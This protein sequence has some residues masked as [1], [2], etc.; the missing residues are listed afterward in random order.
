MLIIHPLIKVSEKNWKSKITYADASIHI[1]KG[2]FSF[3]ELEIQTSAAASP[4]WLLAIRKL[5]VNIDYPSWFM[6][7]LKID[8][9][10][11]H[12]IIFSRHE[13]KGSDRQVERMFSKGGGKSEKK[14]DSEKNEKPFKKGVLIKHLIIQGKLE[15][16]TVYDSGKSDTVKI[17][18]FNVNKKDVLFDGR[19]EAFMSS[20]L[21]RVP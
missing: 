10:M 12:D 16:E 7:N 3:D 19:P 8:R 5:T 1:W 21:K 9:L 14:K 2:E 4:R 15:L 13:N 18:S 17:E 11:I 6:D 20:L